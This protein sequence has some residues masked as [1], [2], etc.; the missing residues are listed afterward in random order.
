MY[1]LK[2]TLNERVLNFLEVTTMTKV[3]FARRTGMS[4][5][6]LYAWLNGSREISERLCGSISGF[7]SDYVRQL[8]ELAK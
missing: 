7:M 8:T 1:N 4:V 3:E 5:Q 2:K 6:T